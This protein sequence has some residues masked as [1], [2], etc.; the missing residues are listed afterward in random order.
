MNQEKLNNYF[1]I[2]WTP[3][4]LSD[5]ETSGRALL[6]RLTPG[7][8]VIDIGCGL[9]LFKG[10][11]PNLIGID[12]V[13]DQADIKTTIEEFTTD[14]KFNVALSTCLPKI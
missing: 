14:Q 8:Q 11:I 2:K 1:K 5:Y 13:F 4:K 12:P 6:T 7:D 10:L 9:N 3:T